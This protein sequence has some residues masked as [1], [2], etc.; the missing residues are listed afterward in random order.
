MNRILVV[1]DEDVIRKAILTLLE[2]NQYEATGVASVEEAINEQLST[3]NLILA[4][5]RLPGGFGTD[6]LNEAGAV[7]LIIMTSHASVRSAVESMK[8]GATDYIS[9][10]FDHDELLLVIERSLRHNQLYAQNNAMH[11]DLRGLFPH[12]AIV[13]NSESLQSI[14][15]E[16]A[17]LPETEKLVFMH[18]ERGTGK[19]LLARLAHRAGGRADRQLVFADLPQ[20]ETEALENLLLGTDSN[21]HPQKQGL[22]QEANGGTLVIRNID[23]LPLSVQA[24]LAAILMAQTRQSGALRT[25]SSRGALDVRVIALCFDTPELAVERKRLH[26]ELAELFTRNCVQIPALRY[27]RQD[28][29]MMAQH[30]L[31]L[32]VRRYRRRKVRLS[33]S[34]LCAIE[35]YDWPGNITELKSSV[36][37]GAL[38]CDSEEITPFHLGLATGELPGGPSTTGSQAMSLDAYFRFIVLSHQHSLSETE[39]ASRLGISRKALW[40]RRQRMDLPRP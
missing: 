24:K 8:L 31:Q 25:S 20:F 18:G 40:E 38:L 36:E 7:P 28:L 15:N 17:T 30:Y 32:F 39:L 1:E 19:E 4:D 6:L 33:E 5:L 37:R 2:R 35:S 16:V 13:S 9:K 34:A 29:R 3:F 14:T 11:R 21:D 26:P 10:P 22:L 23:L 27:R 12:D